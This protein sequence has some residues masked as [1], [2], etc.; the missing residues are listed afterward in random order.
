MIFLED[1]LS[2]R[3]GFF[4]TLLILGLVLILNSQRSFASEGYFGYLYTTDTTPANNWEYEQKQTLRIGKARGTYTAVDLRSEFEYGVTDK[5]QAAFYLNSSYNYMQNQYDPENIS[6]NLPDR[7]EFNVNGVS[8][9]LLYRLLSPYKDG[10]GLGFY[11]EPEIAVRNAMTG[12]SGIERSLETR[13][14]LQKDFFGDRMVSALNIMTE[15]EWEI[16]DAGALSKE[17]WMEFTAGVN[18]RVKNN[19]FLGVEFRNHM[20]FP[21]MNLQVQEHSAYFL[22]ADV[23]YGGEKYWWTVTVLPQVAGWPRYLGIGSDG[24]PVQ[25]SYAHLGQHE[26][27]EV[28]VAFGIPLGGE[29]EHSH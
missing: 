25:S 28:R 11:V 13:I 29:H 10:I 20:E 14:I 27:L 19:W 22:G 1:V 8:V 17:L 26:N 15:P 5:F 23:H 24:N 18:Y 21:D 6:A 7:N 3:F 12:T 9:E 16:G 2:F 4:P